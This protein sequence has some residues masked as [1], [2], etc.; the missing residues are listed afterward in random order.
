MNRL[1]LVSLALLCFALAGADEK[2]VE[3]PVDSARTTGFL[4]LRDKG[5]KPGEKAGVPFLDPEMPVKPGSVKIQV[6]GTSLVDVD[7]K[8]TL[9]EPGNPQGA[10]GKIDYSN[11][12]YYVRFKQAPPPG[13][14]LR[15][16]YN[17]V[18][19]RTSAAAPAT[20]PE[21]VVTSTDATDNPLAPAVR[22]TG[23]ENIS[24][25]IPT[26][27]NPDMVPNGP[28]N[29]MPSTPNDI[30][31]LLAPIVQKYSLPGMAAVIVHDNRITSTGVTGIRKEGRPELLTINDL[32]HIGSDTKSMTATLLEYV[33]QNT[34]VKWDSKVAPL[35]GITAVDPAY[36]NLTVAQLLQ[37]RGG[38]PAEADFWTIQS[39]AGNDLVK[40]RQA[41]S[42]T[43][44]AR[45]P[46]VTPG[47]FL[48]SNVSFIIAGHVAE[49]VLGMPWETLMTNHMFQP[50]SMATGGYGAPGTTNV[51]DQPRGH[52][53]NGTPIEPG[54]VPGQ[55]AA[56]NAPMLG[57]AGTVHV[58]LLD[59]AKYVNTHLQAAQGPQK[60]ADWQAALGIPGFYKYED[61]A[62][63]QVPVTEGQAYAMGWTVGLYNGAPSVLYHAG[64]NTLW[65]AVVWVDITHDLAVLVVTNQGGDDAAAATNEAIQQL[66]SQPIN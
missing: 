65:Y 54:N 48:Y 40:A 34:D 45:P 9:R 25:A 5:F 35:L 38:I 8:G 36:A 61:F 53:S 42:E 62:P 47:T 16:T 13:S 66:L 32:Y 14:Q 31:A 7:G 17:Y 3:I 21:P 63:L 33:V 1:I 51:Y 49:R 44:L 10:R 24:A 26:A 29:M 27:T 41:L 2:S 43:I 6:G 56:D 4:Y 12:L 58:S 59:W 60:F 11:G 19:N 50:N 52:T 64:S 18:D 22:Y 28:T 39:S 57:P 30:S 37:N 46:A 55:Q 15:A 23:T 20:A